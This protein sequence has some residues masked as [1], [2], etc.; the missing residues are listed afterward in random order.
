MKKVY[1]TYGL[2]RAGNTLLGSI[3][4]QNPRIN[5][6]ANSVLPE[7]MF[8]LSNIKQYDTAYN[9]FPD[10]SSLDN[11]LK[12]LFDSYYQDWD[13][14]F[15][16]ERGAWITPFNFLL[17]ERYFQSD[18]KIVVLVRNVLDVIKS[19]L[20]LCD[21]DPDFYINVRYNEL[22]PTTLYRSEVEEKCDLIM[23]KG[24]MVDKMLYS[25][26]WLL[27]NK[28]RDCLHFVE[29][30]NL[31]KDPEAE[32]KGLYDFY[33][34]DHFDHHFT[35][36]KQFSVNNT[37]YDDSIPGTALDM[38][39]IRTDKIKDIPCDIQL[40]QTVIDRYSNIE[41]WRG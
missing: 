19:Y 33:G 40:P 2:P 38:H 35:N 37:S 16:I 30:E 23:Q 27:E 28:K 14:D 32:V 17:L 1:F 7:M 13:G 25:I 9:N 20:H 8:V 22:D 5:A 31:A 34:I 39:K 24:E 41:T 6:T 11:V 29:Y 26:N 3:L 15:I 18:I 12:N 36:L 4:N 21:A 10:E